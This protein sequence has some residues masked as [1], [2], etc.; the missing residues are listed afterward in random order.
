[1]IQAIE[2]VYN[3]Y[4]F[5]SRLEARWAVFFDALGIKYEY[6]KE[7]FDL[8][9]AGW[10]LPDFFIPSANL[11]VEIKGSNPSPEDLTK[12]AEFSKASQRIVLVTGNPFPAEYTI[13]WFSG[14]CEIDLDFWVNYAKQDEV[15]RCKLESFGFGGYVWAVTTEYAFDLRVVAQSNDGWH[16]IAQFPGPH[17]NV[18]WPISQDNWND[19]LPLKTAYTA[20]RQ[21]R[22]E[23]GATPIIR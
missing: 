19:C 23:H 7:G 15:F 4:R 13:R 1:M 8:G 21:A 14:G 22:F 17:Q 16:F 2:T 12:V 6:E 10:Y 11:W 18:S 9:E 5:R 20:A 3:G